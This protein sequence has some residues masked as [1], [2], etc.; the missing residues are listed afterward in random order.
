M[1]DID[2]MLERMKAGTMNIT[3]A[4]WQFQDD[5]KLKGLTHPDKIQEFLKNIDENDPYEI[6]EMPAIGGTHQYLVKGRDVQLPFMQDGAMAEQGNDLMASALIREQ[7]EVY[8]DKY[9]WT[10]DMIDQA[11]AKA[12]RSDCTSCEEKKI[13]REVAEAVKSRL[14]FPQGNSQNDGPIRDKTVS[15]DKVSMGSP[16]PA[17]ADCARKHISQAIILIQESQQGYPAHRWLAVGHLAEAADESL[18]EW[19]QIA[20][21]LREERLELMS[22][23]M[24]VPNLMKYLEEWPD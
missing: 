18:G 11:L 17:C 23:P 19:P 6:V 22:D 15:V 4:V 24:Y 12:R 13:L 7:L 10:A 1:I 20:A 5:P 14:D 8:K 3:W 9:P 2:R 16:R 21:E